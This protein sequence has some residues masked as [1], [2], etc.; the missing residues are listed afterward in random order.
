MTNFFSRATYLSL[1]L[2][3]RPGLFF[4]IRLSNPSVLKAFM[5]RSAVSGCTFHNFAI[6]WQV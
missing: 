5:A 6:S 1:A 4:G 2:G 3:G